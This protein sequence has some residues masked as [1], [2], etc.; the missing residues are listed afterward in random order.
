VIYEVSGLVPGFVGAGETVGDEFHVGIVRL[1]WQ[2]IAASDRIPFQANL[3]CP[4]L[5]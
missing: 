2:A 3:G 4:A 5:P 1:S